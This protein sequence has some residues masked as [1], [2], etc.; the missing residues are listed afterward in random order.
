MNFHLGEFLA[1]TTEKKIH[2]SG[3]S[4]HTGV[5]SVTEERKLQ[6]SARNRKKSDGTDQ[7]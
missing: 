5:P 6:S 1:A 4:L 7:F 2:F 3:I